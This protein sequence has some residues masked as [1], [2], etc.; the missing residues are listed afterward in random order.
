[1]ILNL[2]NENLYLPIKAN[3]IKLSLR[4]FLVTI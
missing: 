3:T 4:C 1:M 2:L